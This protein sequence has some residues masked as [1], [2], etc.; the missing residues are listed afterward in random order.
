MEMDDRLTRN[1]ERWREAETEGRVEV[2]DAAFDEM[3]RSVVRPPVVSAEFTARTVEAIVRAGERDVRRA[4][5]VR[6]IVVPALAVG[7]AVAVYFSAGMLVAGLSSAVVWLLNTVIGGVVT[8]V[9]AMQSGPDG[10]SIL[11]SL[12]RAVAAVIANPVVTV[13]IFAIQGFAIAALIV[14][15]RLL[16]SDR[17]SFR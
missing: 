2:A 1:Y 4:Q 10:W 6:T 14:L 5:R 13:T 12:G 9:T 16:G 15:R 3:Y 7:L 11:S 17:E 8:I